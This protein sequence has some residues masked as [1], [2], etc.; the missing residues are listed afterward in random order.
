MYDFDEAIERRGTHC[1][2]WDEMERLYG[3]PRDDGLAMWVADMDFRAPPAVNAALRAAAE[4]GV[5][6]YFGDSRA[7]LDAVTGWMRRRH[8]WEVDAEEVATVHGVVSGLGICL[9]AFTAPGD[10]VILF[11]PVYHA[12]ARIIAANGREVVE[13]P[14]V[15][16]GGRYE[17]DLDGLAASLRG[18]ER[19][20]VFCSPHNPGGRI[21]NPT[22][23]R[24]LAGFCRAHDLLLVCDEIHHDIVLPGNRHVPLP[25]A[26]PDSRDRL[27][28]LT[29]TTKAFNI[30]GALTGNVIIGDAELRGRFAA[31]HRAAGTSV[32]RFG[33]LAATAAY[34]EGDAWIDALC[35]YL[36]GN[37]EA[38]AGVNAIPG[39]SMMPM[40]STYLA[41]V[42]F[43]GT[44][45]VQ[46]EI[47][48]RIQGRARIAASHGPTFGTG[49]AGFMRFNIG[50]NRARVTEAV[51]RLREAFGDL[52]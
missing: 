25:V 32:N 31:E 29:A 2:K 28:M 30:P 48:A 40:Q 11:A 45:M 10:G 47:V 3:V 15:Q 35:G 9:R 16:R 7:Y 21:W 46:E 49:G 23:L 26:A 41:W 33:V 8:G 14:L 36:A 34:A 27:I 13:S 19:M 37:A 18:H 43:N 42:D 39:V 51:E 52:Q 17:M 6:G 24:A 50:S 1:Q 5:H 44:G 4:H 20:V 38:M 12:F 22:E